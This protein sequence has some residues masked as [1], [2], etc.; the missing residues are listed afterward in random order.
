MKK[1]K[2]LHCVEFYNPSV[3]GAQEVVKQLSEQ[4]VAMGH[5]V[6]VATTKMSQRKNRTING[7]KIIELDIEG[8]AVRG[9]HG[10]DIDNYKKLLVK[11]NYDVVMSYAAQ[12]WTTDLMFEVIG[13]I[14]AKTV[15]VPCGYSS[16]RNPAYAEYYHILPSFLR[17]LSATVYLSHDYRDINFAKHNDLRNIRIIPNG[18]SKKEFL[19]TNKDAINQFK[20]RYDV[21]DTETII[22]NVSN[23]TGSKGHQETIKSFLKAKI[24][25]ATLI[26]VG[27]RSNHGGCYSSCARTA[28]VSNNLRSL[29]IKDNKKIIMLSTSRDKVITAMQACDI[30][31]FLSNIECSPLVLFESVA[32][33]KPFISNSCGNSSEIAKWTGAGLI[34]KS[35]E[36]K[37]GYMQT[38]IDDAATAIQ[39]LV[40][41]KNM[42]VKLGSK[43]RKAWLENYSWEKIAKQYLDLY[44]EISK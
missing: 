41:N 13:L 15:L 1:L 29:M 34:V 4:M 12:Q 6:S 16:I 24:S 3:G 31:I 14:K 23:H 27:N 37:L 44:I 17:Q 35:I 39:K 42:R 7:V 18:A 20:E 19:D 38:D 10:S 43:G 32:A 25:N 2:I 22:L 33:G 8:N 28:W 26:I 21:Q 30:F 5:Q 36:N 9:Y 40:S 11:G